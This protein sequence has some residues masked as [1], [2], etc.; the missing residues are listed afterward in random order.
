VR[1]A[2]STGFLSVTI[3]G[4]KCL[5]YFRFEDPHA[6]GPLT[7]TSRPM[8][9]TSASGLTLRLLDD[10]G[11]QQLADHGQRDLALPVRRR[12]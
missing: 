10:A 5:N 8:L 7:G 9:D 11:L 2:R 12:D 6:T 1:A 4:Q 3:A